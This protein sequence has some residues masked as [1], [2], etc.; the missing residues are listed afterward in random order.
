[1]LTKQ[2]PQNRWFIII[3]AL[4]LGLLAALI[5]AFPQW[6]QLVY[7]SNGGAVS[8]P[9]VES[10]HPYENNT[11]ESWTIINDT[12]SNAAQVVFGR[13]ELEA[14]VDVLEVRDG[15]GTL[16][17]IISS[18]SPSGTVSAIVPGDRIELVLKSDG[19]GRAWGFT[20]EALLPVT[21][22]TALYSPHPYPNAYY[23]NTILSA[24]AGTTATQLR[25]DRIELEDN[26]DYIAI[27]DSNFNLYDWITTDQ[28]NYT[29]PAVPGNLIRVEF[30]TDGN[31]QDWGYNVAEI[32]A[33]GTADTP[34]TPPN[35]PLTFSQTFPLSGTQSIILSNPAPTANTSKV[36]FEYINMEAGDTLEIVGEDGT[37]IQTFSGTNTLADVWSD[38]LPGND[39]TFNLIATDDGITTTGFLVDWILPGPTNPDLIQSDHP[40][41]INQTTEFIIPNPSISA[42][43]KLHFPR[44]ELDNFDKLWILDENDTVIQRFEPNGTWLD[45]WTDYI[46]GPFVK[47][48]FISDCCSGAAW[49]FRVDELVTSD[50]DAI[51][52]SS[53]PYASNGTVEWTVANPWIG[54]S[55]TQFHFERL[56]LGTSDS[57]AVLDM[58][59][60]VLYTYPAGTTLTNEWSPFFT[61][62]E[63]KLRLTSDCCNEGWGFRIN[64]I[65]PNSPD[66]I[67]PA[68]IG[69]IYINIFASANVYLDGNLHSQIDIPGEY[70]IPLSSIGTHTILLEYADGTQTININIDSEGNATI[71]YLP[72]IAT[73]D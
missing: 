14:G 15:D 16:I 72:L 43:V 12:G 21:Y 18:R 22:E 34:I 55:I 39:I 42:S 45:V 31:V 26:V 69:G 64:D 23:D 2:S 57:L 67:T 11:T 29:T 49:G 44:I 63:F 32:I 61:G 56:E 53:H 8:I 50:L 3:F 48:Q 58:D 28:T 27:R 65:S 52:Q 1:M 9:I 37:L 33:T 40:F 10:A 19:T 36:H 73:E 25:F 46:P 4:T 20:A 13:L 62:R 71:N 7:G 35:G 6:S 60:T 70:K 54:A 38:Y 5:V 68:Y 41:P 59:N 66:P 17:E 47:V 24:P 51:V 30:V